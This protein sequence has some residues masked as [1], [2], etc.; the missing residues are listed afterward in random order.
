MTT[1]V[2]Y[3]KPR[4]INVV[5]V[6]LVALLAMAGYATYLYLPLYLTKHEAYRV[7]EETGSKVAGRAGF[8]AD[9]GAAR[10]E[11]RLDMQRQIKGLGIDDPNIETW[12]ELE[13]K[14]VRLGVVYSTWVEWPFDVVERQESVY[15][16]EHTI[17]VH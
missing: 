9:D 14:Q 7:L 16:L 3:N 12:I 1:P 5:S 11:L 6:V 10:D 4:R 17:V 8:Y 15:E 13:G 2:K